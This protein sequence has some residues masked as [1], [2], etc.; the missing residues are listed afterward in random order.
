M[1]TFGSV[2]SGI[3]AASVAFGTL[4]WGASWFAEVDVAASAVLAYR[5]G[6]TSPVNRVG[7][8]E[9][10]IAQIDWGD[11]LVNWG[12]MAAL[13]QLIRNGRA[14]SPDVLCGGTPCQ[15]FSLAGKRGGLA[16]P[17]GQLTM[18]FVEI[19]DAMDDMRDTPCVVLWE[20]VPGVL[21]DKGN[22]F[23]NFIAALV[24]DNDAIEPGPKPDSERSSAHWA[25]KKDTCEHVPK[26]P[27]AGVAVGPK[28]AAAWVVKD[29]KYFGLA[30]R[31]KRVFVVASGRDGFDPAEILFE[32]DGVRR[33]FAPSG[34]EV[35]DLTVSV[36]TSVVGKSCGDTDRPS[37]VDW[38]ADIASTLN[39]AFGEKLG[40][41]NQHVNSGCPLF[42][43]YWRQVAFGEYTNDETASTLKARDFKGPTDLIVCHGTQDPC[44]STTHAFTLGTNCGGENVIVSFEKPLLPENCGTIIANSGGGGWGNSVDHAAASY[45]VPTE[46]GAIRRLMPIEFERLQGFP[47]NYT[48][49]PIGNRM[50]S[51]TQR[52]KQL[53][54][55]W[56]VPVVAWIA[57]RIDAKL[58]FANKRSAADIWLTS[59]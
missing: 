56:P 7:G 10:Q 2:A 49:V 53:G 28:R 5:Y 42:V 52:Y 29:A 51:D 43:K 46:N 36:G 15:G 39:A 44:V 31:R 19:A 50:S 8:S 54:N 34:E 30:Q 58:R 20:N 21:T 4:G 1:I 18:S 40:L 11:K 3:E 26:W 38:P 37:G 23:G 17:R 12:D 32:F 47:D 13:P 41:D 16:D 48:S 27:H 45:M 33:D 22:A 6:A 25:W 35:E 14:S 9:R 57:A 55:S 24:G 59:P